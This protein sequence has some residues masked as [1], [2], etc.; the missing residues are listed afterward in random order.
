MV[1]GAVSAEFQG[2][3]CHEIGSSMLQVIFTPNTESC[4]QNNDLSL[5]VNMADLTLCVVKWELSVVLF[6]QSALTKQFILKA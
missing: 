4:V 6:D 3:R 1:L 5:L 2:K